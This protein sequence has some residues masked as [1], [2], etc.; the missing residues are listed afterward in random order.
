MR[1]I[2]KFGSDRLESY[3]T[4]LINLQASDSSA[5]IGLYAQ[6]THPF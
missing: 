2:R 5:A 6:S 4:N 1:D 3:R